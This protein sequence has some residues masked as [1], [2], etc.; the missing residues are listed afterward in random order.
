MIIFYL[1]LITQ[2]LD[3]STKET[4]R[5]AAKLDSC[6]AI[7][8][9]KI[10]ETLTVSVQNLRYTL[11]SLTTIT[12]N[13]EDDYYYDDPSV[14][15][16]GFRSENLQGGQTFVVTQDGE[17]V[18]LSDTVLGFDLEGNL[19]FY[20]E[21]E[22]LSIGVQFNKTLGAGF[23]KFLNENFGFYTF[24][25]FRN[26]QPLIDRLVGEA[27]RLT[28]DR[29]NNRI[30][31]VDPEDIF[32]N[33]KEVYLGYTLKIQEDKPIDENSQV[34]IRRRGVALDNNEL[35]VASTKLT[36]TTNLNTIV[37]ELKFILKQ[38]VQEGLIGIGT[39]DDT[40]NEISDSDVENV[41]ESIGA[42]KVALNDVK[43]ENN[44]KLASN[45]VVDQGQ[46][47]L[48]TRTGNKVF[49]TKTIPASSNLKNDKR[50]NRKPI[51]VNQ[52]VDDALAEF[53]EDNPSLKK[54]SSTVARIDRL[55]SLQL[56]E[57]QRI[58]NGD[59][60]G[61]E[62]RVQK[63]KENILS[64]LDPNPDK[65]KEV[66]SVTQNWYEGLKGKAET[67]FN[68]LVLYSGGDQSDFEKYFDKILK[69]ELKKWVKYLGTK[70]YT[71]NEITLG[72]DVDE[73]QDN[74]RLEIEDNGNVIVKK[75]SGFK[76]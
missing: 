74:Y 10:K 43:A 56:S 72:I 39:L 63:A 5:L 47:G 41:V 34:A 1:S 21:L 18:I 20:A 64:S 46:E 16:E 67:D 55:D 4:A 36:F 65:V 44:N 69:E 59:D 40:P 27:D 30:K 28:F 62:E 70:G 51:K 2:G 48:Q 52:L 12:G 11:K 68:T 6:D 29:K 45:L 33:F 53:V 19:L 73:I 25:K 75:R 26:K 61:A 8:D 15:G 66:S 35:L 42:N 76:N 17:L 9:D 24:D 31:E 57:L 32:G 22:S 23:R 50:S 13:G 7:T 60:L 54:I 14:P 3:V 58:P 38:K 71:D 49:Q 37:Q